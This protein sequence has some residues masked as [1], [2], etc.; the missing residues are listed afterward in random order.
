M[1]KLPPA[2]QKRK[3]ATTSI[4]SDALRKKK[5]CITCIVVRST[6]SR[7]PNVRV[8]GCLMRAASIT[9]TVTM[10]ALKTMMLTM[11][12][13]YQAPNTCAF[14]A[15]LMI[16][17][18]RRIVSCIMIARTWPDR[19]ARRSTAHSMLRCRNEYMMPNMRLTSRIWITVTT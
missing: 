8:M 1:M 9:T 5:C 12:I 18:A 6:P 15:I 19:N 10:P 16:P 13:A 7:K 3:N 4:M 14:T 17:S 11:R 2:P